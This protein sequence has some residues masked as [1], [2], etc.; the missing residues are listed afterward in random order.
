MLQDELPRRD[1][2]EIGTASAEEIARQPDRQTVQLEAQQ[3]A[4]EAATLSGAGGGEKS[5]SEGSSGLSK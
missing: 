2:L 5:I 4:L 3:R 1:K